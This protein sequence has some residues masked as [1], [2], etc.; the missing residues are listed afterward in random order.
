MLNPLC[1]LRKTS[2][3]K[4]SFNESSV[5]F[6]NGSVFRVVE[7][8]YESCDYIICDDLGNEWAD[9]LVFRKDNKPE[10]YFIHSKY[11]KQ[12][13]NS[14]SNMHDIVGQAMKNIGNM[15]FDAKMLKGKFAKFG[16]NYNFGGVKTAIPR[17]RKGC[18]DMLIG[19]VD[20][21]L[22]KYDVTRYC[23]LVCPF[24]SKKNIELEF[25]K[26]LNGDKVGGHITQLMWIL[27]SYANMSRE[28]NVVPIIHCLP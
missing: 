8:L 2:S 10:I 4:G 19:D 18:L 20:N 22:K 7:T 16:E 15:F 17:L 24:L 26:I 5:E 25:Y 14:A 6:D 9:H 3:E 12:S 27:S 28:S 1:E 11:Y 13:S 23:V 21:L